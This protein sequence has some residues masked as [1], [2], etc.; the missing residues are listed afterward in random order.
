MFTAESA[1]FLSFLHHRKVLKQAT[2]G[3]SNFFRLLDRF[4]S[5]Q[6]F[7]PSIQA[8]IHPSFGRRVCGWSWDISFSKL[9]PITGP[10]FS[11]RWTIIWR[12]SE[13]YPTLQILSRA[14]GHSFIV[15]VQPVFG[16]YFI[17]GDVYTRARTLTPALRRV[18]ALLRIRQLKE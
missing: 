4:D 13:T 17:N 1:P 5:C 10:L 14:T 11:L 15:R 18:Y 6:P 8:F 7:F 2:S 9:P 3:R 16:Y 12:S